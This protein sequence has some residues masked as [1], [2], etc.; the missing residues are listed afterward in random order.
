MRLPQQTMCGTAVRGAS[1]NNVARIPLA[2]IKRIENERGACNIGVNFHGA[3]FYSHRRQ[4][5][6]SKEENMEERYE[7][8]YSCV[9]SNQVNYT[10]NTRAVTSTSTWRSLSFVGYM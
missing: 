9:R 3:I 10:N 5:W 4:R 7:R 6:Y 2:T 1:S 8:A